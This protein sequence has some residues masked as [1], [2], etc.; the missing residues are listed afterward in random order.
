MFFSFKVNTNK[1]SVAINNNIISITLSKSSMVVKKG[2]KGVL[3]YS[4]KQVMRLIRKLVG[5]VVILLLLLLV[6][7][8]LWRQLEMELL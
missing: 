7:L 8:V 6:L 1:P 4:I 3:K 5:C 2:K